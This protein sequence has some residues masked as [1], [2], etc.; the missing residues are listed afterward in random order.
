[1]R[2]FIYSRPLGRPDDILVGLAQIATVEPVRRK[3]NGA[4]F[5]ALRL[6][7]GRLIEV[8]ETWEAVRDAIEDA[9]AEPT[10]PP[11]PH[12]VPDADGSYN[13]EYRA[14]PTEAVPPQAAAKVEVKKRGRPPKAQL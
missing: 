7:D 8:E 10:K 9:G 11:Y 14:A 1:M 12:P 3:R 6:G 13:I 4:L 5:A 2:N